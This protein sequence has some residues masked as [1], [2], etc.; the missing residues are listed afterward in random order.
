MTTEK[1]W[2][3]IHVASA[4]SRISSIYGLLL[5]FSSR[6]RVF[7][8]H[9]RFFSKIKLFDSSPA[10]PRPPN[11]KVFS[12]RLTTMVSY[13]HAWSRL[14]IERNSLLPFHAASK[15]V[16][17]DNRGDLRRSWWPPK[18]AQ[19]S[20][21]RPKSKIVHSVKA[22]RSSAMNL[23]LQHNTDSFQFHHVKPTLDFFSS[24]LWRALLRPNHFTV[25]FEARNRFFY[26]PRAQLTRKVNIDTGK[27]L[28]HS[29]LCSRKKNY[30]TK[31]K[32]TSYSFVRRWFFRPLC[33]FGKQTQ[34]PAR[35]HG[36]A[37]TGRECIFCSNLK[38]HIER[39]CSPLRIGIAF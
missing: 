10:T 29:E 33:W 36:A 9:A 11:K 4:F 2:P 26:D 16:C 30:I 39:D 24:R 32:L 23:R 15:W 27:N 35:Y 14:I 25:A 19:A 6:K 21:R 5:A 12:E 20:E 17:L 7:G 3:H 8:F 28:A 22:A 1:T 18:R 38:T 31:I 37:G 34:R 13:A